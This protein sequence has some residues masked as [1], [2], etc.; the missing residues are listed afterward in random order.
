MDILRVEKKLTFVCKPTNV[1]AYDFNFEMFFECTHPHYFENEEVCVLRTGA[2]ADY[3]NEYEELLSSGLRL[4]NSPDEHV[5]ASELSSWYPLIADFTPKSICLDQLPAAEEV[6]SQFGWPVFVKGSR[7][8]SKHNPELSIARDALHY[9]G[10]VRKFQQDPILHW[11]KAVIREFVPLQPVSGSVAGKVPPS[12]EFRTFWWRNRCVGWGRYW[13]QVAHYDA[14]D[15]EEGI[16]LARAAAV[17]VNVPFLVI[18][19]AKSAAGEWLIIECNDAQ[20][21]GYVGV[22]PQIMWQNVLNE[23]NACA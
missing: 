21:S 13:Y 19:I 7:Q 14:P 5:R 11:Q 6:E 12:L 17:R 15:I 20:E 4:I 3:E 1:Q 2:V 18:D 16:Q 22:T 10:I 23:I 8:T 9:A